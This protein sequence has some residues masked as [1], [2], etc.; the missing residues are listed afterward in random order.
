MSKKQA[1]NYRVFFPSGNNNRGMFSIDKG[2]GT[3]RIYY[4]NVHIVGPC[5]EL[6]AFR[7]KLGSVERVACLKVKGVLGTVYYKE[8]EE[9][10]I[11]RHAIVIENARK[12]KA[13]I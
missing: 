13:N 3:R 2:K 9:L 1:V 11:N 7:E 6:S 12:S 10:K 8:G 4:D 5:C